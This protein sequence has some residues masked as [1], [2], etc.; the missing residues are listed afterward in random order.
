MNWILSSSALTERGVAVIRIIFGCLLIIHGSQVFHTD[1]ML[2]YGPWLTDLGV[3][4]PL[5]SAYLG[6][7]LELVGGLLLV[8]GILTRLACIMLMLTFLFITIVMAD[9]EIL[10]DGQ[11]PFLFFLISAIFFFTGARGWTV[12]SF[13]AKK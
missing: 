2:S 1:E 11:H 3:P 12:S 9:G 7:V 4:F 8:L 6:K 10:T 5:F 13:F